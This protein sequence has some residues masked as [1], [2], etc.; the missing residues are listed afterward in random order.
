MTQTTTPVQA[1]TTATAA[2][3]PGSPRRRTLVALAGTIFVLYVV[4]MATGKDL[5]Y[6]A[7][8]ADITDHY[9]GMSQT[10]TRVGAYAAMAFAAV[11]L[12]FGAA[13][14]SAL[15]G[16]GRTWLAD[17]V[18]LGFGAL[19]ATLAS[20]VVIDVALWEAVDY[21]DESAIR[22]LVTISDAGFLP[23]MTSMIA[24]YVGAGL[25]GLTT[26]SLPKWLAVASVVV[27]VL[28]PLGPLGF[29]GAMLLPI[30]LHRG[31]SH[32]APGAVRLTS[33]TPE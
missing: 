10:A 11:V 24:I 13:F 16:A 3:A 32:G 29:I 15:R 31:R 8:L 21:G 27:G 4:F 2:A 1:S 26:K 17:V 20:W 6:D 23:L 14:R 7:K 19:A 9:E 12:F 33:R 5:G 22:A 25:A 18:L 30:W 28:A